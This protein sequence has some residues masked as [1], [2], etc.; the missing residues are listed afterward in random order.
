[1]AGDCERLEVEVNDA[2]DVLLVLK[3]TDQ[4]APAVLGFD[5]GMADSLGK[6]L[7]EAAREA[8]FKRTVKSHG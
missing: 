8:H 5:P 1:M 3:L 2:G 7:R 6:R 4:I